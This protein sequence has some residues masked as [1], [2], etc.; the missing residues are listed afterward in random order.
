MS[1]RPE[2]PPHLRLTG[3]HENR[4]VLEK[5]ARQLNAEAEKLDI[6]FQFNPI[7]SKLE[8]LE[9]EISLHVKMG[10]ALAISSVLQLHRLLAFD[11]NSTGPSS[12]SSPKI[13]T[14]LSAL[15]SLSPKIMVITEKDSDHNGLLLEE[16]SIQALN[17]YAALFDCMECTVPRAS[18]ER[19]K[20][21]HLLFGEEIKNIV[22]CEG[23]E[24]K[25]RHE[26]VDKWIARLQLCGFRR[27]LLSHRVMMHGN[28]LLLDQ[29][30]HIGY[31]IKDRDGCFLICWHEYPIF[32]I[33][34]WSFYRYNGVG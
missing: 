26:K 11:C 9:M 12:S 13:I 17:Y 2:G 25:E 4:V 3:V 24:R 20:V 28:R 14:F 22:S 15:R 27:E 34:A 33:T 5:M 1:T 23:V 31:N 32:S 10:E 29:N 16:R 19:Q 30:N 21:E 6:P 7:V 18:V 8:D